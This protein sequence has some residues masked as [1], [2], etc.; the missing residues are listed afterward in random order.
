M[1]RPAA[2]FYEFT[3]ILS[4]TKDFSARALTAP[5]HSLSQLFVKLE[6]LKLCANAHGALLYGY[7]RD[8][9]YPHHGYGYAY[10]CAYVHGNG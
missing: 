4:K 7:A 3:K 1:D 10:G 2:L 6:L 8:C 5:R 9:R